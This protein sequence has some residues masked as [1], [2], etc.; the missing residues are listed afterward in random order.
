MIQN[1]NECIHGHAMNGLTLQSSYDC[2]SPTQLVLFLC[3]CNL[4]FNI[5]FSEEQNGW[6]GKKN[7]KDLRRK[8]IREKKEEK[9]Q[10]GIGDAR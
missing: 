8:R 4:F 10:E 3:F 6:K 7:N 5:Q 1:Y 9:D 2:I